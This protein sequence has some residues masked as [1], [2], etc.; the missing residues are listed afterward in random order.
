[1]PHSKFN[2]PY[3]TG[4]SLALICAALAGCATRLSPPTTG[5]TCCNL[6]PYYGAVS[7]GNMLGSSILPAGTAVRS[8]TSNAAGTTATS[9][10]TM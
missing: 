3:L 10:M 6:R 2:K 8:N 9:A 5:Y 7:S 4:F 1:M